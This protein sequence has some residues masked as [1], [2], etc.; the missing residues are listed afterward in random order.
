VYGALLTFQCE[1]PNKEGKKHSGDVSFKSSTLTV[2]VMYDEWYMIIIILIII[3]LRLRQYRA[4][5]RT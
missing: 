4:Q 1:K 3:K 5:W 2:L